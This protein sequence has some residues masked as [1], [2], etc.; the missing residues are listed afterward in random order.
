VP[1]VPPERLAALP[2]PRRIAPGWRVSSYSGLSHGAG[3]ESAAS[4][5]DART[6]DGVPAVR[7]P[8]AAAADD[9][10]RFPRGAAAGDCI[11]ALFERIDFSDPAGWSAGIA[12]A[13]AAHPQSLPGLAPAVGQARLAAMLA[14]L[15]DDVTRT[16]LGD[17]IRLDAITPARRFSE[18]E[19]NLPVAHLPAAE[20][21]Q[22]L[23]ALGYAVP[24]LG[25][26]T[27]QGYLT[28][29]VD[30]VFEQGGRYYVL[31]W[32]SNH[33]GDTPADYAAEPLAAAMAE[34]GYHLQYLLYALALDRYLKRRLPDY[35]HDSHFGGILYLFVRGVRPTWLNADGSPAGVYFHRPAAATIARL[36]RLLAP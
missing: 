26:A 16:P 14:Q 23:K 5:H 36:D 6:H 30:L 11:H 9:I 35:R 1:G 33:L 18:L 17:G 15:L 10:L 29:F 2:P 19:F 28:G 12:A 24:R 22:A 25:F 34:H 20:L 21:N 4:D 3:A 8:A 7:R 31:D 32:K 27:L 13:L